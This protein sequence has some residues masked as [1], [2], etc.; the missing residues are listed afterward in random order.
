V[1][2]STV[3]LDVWLDVACLF[4]TRSDAQRACKSGKVVIDGNA[5]KPHREVRIG[6]EIAITRPSSRKQIVVVRG[7]ADTHVAKAEARA[8]YEDLTPPP[9]EEE[10][11]QRRLERLY[12]A[13]TKP[14]ARL[15]RR[16]QKAAAR[17][18]WT[19]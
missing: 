11:A 9:T 10:V 3:R 5:A 6:Q 1:P 4:K 13:T 19:T 16:D 15:D 12:R 8:L 14:P 18:K 2:E 17:R 7:I